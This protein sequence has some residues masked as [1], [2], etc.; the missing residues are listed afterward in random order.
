MVVRAN[1]TVAVRG[2][3]AMLILEPGAPVVSIRTT[4][5]L[6]ASKTGVLVKEPAPKVEGVA[7]FE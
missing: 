4:V 1:T 5:E 7:V 3:D 6:S 2:A